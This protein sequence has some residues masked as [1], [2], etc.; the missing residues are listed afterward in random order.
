MKS[1]KRDQELLAEAYAGINEGFFD[2]FKSKGSQQEQQPSP[3]V[4]DVADRHY[5]VDVFGTLQKFSENSLMYKS[6]TVKTIPSPHGSAIMYKINIYKTRSKTITH[7]DPVDVIFIPVIIKVND[8]AEYPYPTSFI[9]A[10][11]KQSYESKEEALRAGEEL[12]NREI[13]KR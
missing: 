4:L 10:I 7:T 3:K 6:E 2:R 5:S 9:V 12:F 8:E 13:G 11:S 1:H